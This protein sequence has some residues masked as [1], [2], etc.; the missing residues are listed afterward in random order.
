MG[1]LVAYV[2]FK[3]YIWCMTAQPMDPHGDVDV[4]VT[5]ARS[6]LPELLDTHVREGHVVYLTRYGR[7]VGAVVSAEVAERLEEL[8]DA[9]WSARARQAR[10]ELAAS[11]ER[12]IPWEQAVAELEAADAEADATDGRESR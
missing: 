12:P 6:Q 10:Q 9:Y 2:L 11:G 3:T 4:T 1:P 5:E 8:E 7:R